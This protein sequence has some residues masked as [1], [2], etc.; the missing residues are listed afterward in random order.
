MPSVSSVAI[1]HPPKNEKE[2]YTAL[3]Q[4]KMNFKNGDFILKGSWHYI[5]A[6]ST[7]ANSYWLSYHPGRVVIKADIFPGEIN[8]D[9]RTSDGLVLPVSGTIQD[10]SSVNSCSGLILLHR[11]TTGKEINHSEWTISICLYDYQ[12]DNCEINLRLPLYIASGEG[13]KS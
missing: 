12:Q 7:K 11:S 8:L 2:R 10:E 1:S 13:S 5:M 6:S 4:V 9:D 3:L